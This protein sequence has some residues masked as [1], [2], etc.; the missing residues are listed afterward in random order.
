MAVPKL[1]DL[2]LCRLASGV[3]RV[4]I[5]VRLTTVQGLPGQDNTIVDLF[6]WGAPADGA[7]FTAG[8][9]YV[10]NVPRATNV[11]APAANTWRFRP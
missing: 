2:A 7:P 3:D 5:I 10:L 11:A 6:V 4:G 1:G 9:A 8:P